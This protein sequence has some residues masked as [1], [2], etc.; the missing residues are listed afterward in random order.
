MNKLDEVR[1]YWNTSPCNILYSPK[2]L[3]TKEYFDEVEGRKYFVEAHIPLFAQ[4]DK[5][6]NKKVL[7]IGCG[8]GT[9]TINFA[10]SGAKV[11]V[12]ELSKKSL[13]IAKQRARTYNLN[14]I[15]FYYANAEEL[16]KTVLPEEYD[17]V[18]SFGVIHHTPRP[19]KILNEIKKYCNKNTEIRI[20]LYSKWSWKMFWILLIHGQG[21]FWQIKKIVPE[22][23]EAQSGN[24]ISY[25]YSFREIHKLLK[26]FE[27]SKMRKDHIFPYE[28]KKYKKYEYQYVWYF[29]WIPDLLFKFIEKR[30]GWH[31]L[32]VAKKR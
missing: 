22:Y 1:N 2:T 15:K 32:I 14:N 10:R 20:M 23:S 21:K 25:T 26:D 3:G 4:F 18:Y 9:D 5:W 17:L 16:S 11:T 31:T 19:E 30:L 12:V 6:K 13:E 27:I 28:I 24:P 8:I 29:R 7:E